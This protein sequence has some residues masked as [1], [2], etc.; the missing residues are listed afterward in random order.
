MDF[1]SLDTQD[2]LDCRSW[3][4]SS[5]TVLGEG[6]MGPFIPLASNAGQGERAKVPS[7]S[8]YEQDG[9]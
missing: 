4:H 7:L 2:T 9:A 5:Q 6:S 8:E 3:Y 1:D